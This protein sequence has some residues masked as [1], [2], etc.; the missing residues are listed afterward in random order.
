MLAWQIDP[1]KKGKPQD[2]IFSVSEI[3]DLSENKPIPP[4]VQR[5]VTM[6]G[7]LAD[8]LVVNSP[9]G[10]GEN[11]VRKMALATLL[12]A[13]LWIVIISQLLIR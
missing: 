7:S 2:R 4:R 11:L 1:P 10:G 6:R 9:P 13:S 3:P 5:S 12:F 8:F